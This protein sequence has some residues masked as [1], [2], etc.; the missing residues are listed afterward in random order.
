MRNPQR[1]LKRQQ[2]LEGVV[3]KRET[4]EEGKR[5][6]SWV[7][8][9]T[10]KGQEFVIGGPY[11]QSPRLQKSVPKRNGTFSLKHRKMTLLRKQG[12]VGLRRPS[13]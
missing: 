8:M 10:N 11:F 5:T 3:A 2:Q 1:H 7:K 13:W 4:Y 12:N 9:R 6:G